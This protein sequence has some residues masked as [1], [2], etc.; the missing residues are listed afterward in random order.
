MPN[1]NSFKNF[2]SKDSGNTRASTNGGNSS[3]NPNNKLGGLNNAAMDH[4]LGDKDELKVGDKVD[5]SEEL[6]ANGG[7]PSKLKNQNIGHGKEIDENGNVKNTAAQR[8]QNVAAK[9]LAG[10]YSGGDAAAMDAA[11]KASESGVGRKINDA[12]TKTPGVGTVV[13]AASEELEKDG[14]LDATEGAVE[15]FQSIKSADVKGTAEAVKK[16]A[17]G[18]KKF[19][20]RMLI[21]AAASFALFM[22]AFLIIAAPVINGYL[23]FIDIVDFFKGDETDVDDPANIEISTDEQES[24]QYTTK[25]EKLAYLF[26]NGVP[27]NA[28]DMQNYLVSITVPINDV[29]GNPST[30]ALTVHKKLVANYMG[31]FEDLYKS[32]FRIKAGTHAWRDTQVG[33]TNKTSQHFYGTVVDINPNDNPVCH[34]TSIPCSHSGD[35]CNTVT[36]TYDPANNQFSIEQREADILA[37]HGFKWGLWTGSEDKYP[38]GIK[39]DYM[40]FSYL[41]G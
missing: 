19:V 24:L 30:L 7:S 17:G 38:N 23:I 4:V 37:A 33:G 40:H 18:V 12:L 11:E 3:N 32:G 15:A 27:D 28:E 14:V 29:N 25:A 8:L 35:E 36:G 22:F 21:I 5:R 34:T 1:G 16:T 6:E 31:A 20:K 2:S 39:Y 41:G 13:N 26:P 10:Y 9:G